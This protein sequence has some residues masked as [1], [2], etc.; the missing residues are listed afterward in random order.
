M[1][2][3]DKIANY[4]LRR[5]IFSSIMMFNGLWSR[6]NPSIFYRC[7]PYC[8]ISVI[9]IAFYAAIN[10]IRIHITDLK[11]VMKSASVIFSGIAALAKLM[12]YTFYR[13]DLDKVRYTLDSLV[14]EQLDGKLISIVLKPLL[15]TQRFFKVHVVS[16][17]MVGVVIIGI[18]LAV[19]L[20]QNLLSTGPI[21]YPQF[22]P[23]DYGFEVARGSVMY[24]LSLTFEIYY[25]TAGI[26]ITVGVDNFFLF[27]TCELVGQLCV[28]THQAK[29][30]K[31]S[32]M[33]YEKFVKI[34]KT[35]CQLIECK[36]ILE[37]VH[38]P[39]ILVMFTMNA[40]VL[41]SLL[42]T[43][44]QAERITVKHI[45]SLLPHICSKIL[46]SAAYAWP[47]TLVIEHSKEFQDAIYGCGW[48][49]FSDNKRIIPFIMLIV[50]QR[51]M[52][53]TACSLLLISVDLITSLLNTTC[54]YFLLL[55]SMN[56]QE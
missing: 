54:S 55:Q 24:F 25:L 7:I 23:L 19:A 52:S 28:L 26:C 41:C 11:L 30:M 38:S 2:E 40:I 49:E 43:M 35:H 13:Q 27:Y 29:N 4:F 47:G 39:I 42:F 32:E 6:E 48:N 18:P 14:Q 53:L 50:M 9:L 37:K 1:V 44:N 15:I 22:T 21:N 46:Q 5:K 51:T 3:K 16:S 45:L 8:A 34:V 20:K 56:E 31:T 17:Y 33:T 36:D 10:H 12:C